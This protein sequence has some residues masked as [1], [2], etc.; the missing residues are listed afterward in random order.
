MKSLALAGLALTLAASP[1]LAEG[2]PDKTV[3]LIVPSKPGGGTDVMARIFADYLGRQTGG[4]V[5]VVNVDGG[6]GAIAYN[7]VMTAK[8]DGYT[9]LYNH[10]G[11]LAGY[12][13]GHSDIGL[14]SFTTIG[15]AQNYAP[16][17]YAVAPD[18]PW[19][20][21]KDFVED[22]RVH[23]GERTV[24]VSLG[25]TTHFI[26]G[27]IMMNE[28]VDLKLLEASA[29]VD[30]VAAI[31]GGH[32]E[33]GNLGAGS[34][35]QYEQAGDMK[36]LCLLDPEPHP[37]YPEYETCIQQGVNVSWLAPLVLWG[38]PDMDPALVAEINAAT[39]GMADD[40]TAQ[41][42]LAK[43]DSVFVYYD[44]DAANAMMKAEDEKIAA[45]AEKLGL[46]R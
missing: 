34:A 29:E 16:Q 35:K 40:A 33:M 45:L 21:M 32:I 18:A 3:Q 39:A 37:A 30:K 38:P 10:T 7:Q 41:E 5:V 19:N 22:A 15:I 36:V 31:Q 28:D 23:P 6:G 11:L 17:V 25:R 9:I 2:W 27:L 14:D 13:T 1:A 43:A 24:A 42:A 12:H 20:T 26:A 4:D 46:A 44:V 8:P